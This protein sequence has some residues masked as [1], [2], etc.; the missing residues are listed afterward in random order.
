MS[1]TEETSASVS[2]YQ[3]R[4]KWFN[5]KVGYGFISVISGPDDWDRESV[6]D[7]FAHHSAICVSKEQY[8]YL[9]Q[10]EY[11]EFELSKTD[12]ETH[13]YQ[14]ISIRG[15]KGGNLLCETRNENRSLDTPRRNV[16]SR[17]RYRGAGPRDNLTN[18]EW[19]LVKNQKAR[20]KKI[21]KSNNIDSKNAEKES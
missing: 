21:G 10:G 11:V 3:G 1:S 8:R 19:V 5:N 9:V 17:G 14:A 2:Q 20:G 13:K 6:Q 15:L 12:S 7:I 4:V 16:S 18:E